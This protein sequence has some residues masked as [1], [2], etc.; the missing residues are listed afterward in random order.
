MFIHWQLLEASD[1]IMSFSPCGFG[2]YQQYQTCE[3]CVPDQ[4]L[5]ECCNVQCARPCGHTQTKL[6]NSSVCVAK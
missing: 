4:T 6:R 1:E 5:G 2:D 3:Q